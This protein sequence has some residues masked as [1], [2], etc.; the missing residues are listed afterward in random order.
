MKCK[1]AS[2]N[3]NSKSGDGEFRRAGRELGLFEKFGI[4]L[5]PSSLSGIFQ[6]RLD[7]SFF[8]NFLYRGLESAVKKSIRV[9][10]TLRQLLYFE[11]SSSQSFDVEFPRRYSG[12]ILAQLNNLLHM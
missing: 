11:K 10:P 12:V 7:T 6:H 3:D 1:F 5:T 2:M 4:G 9:W 8:Q